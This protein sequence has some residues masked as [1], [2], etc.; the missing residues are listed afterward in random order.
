MWFF[1][2][3]LSVSLLYMAALLPVRWTGGTY[4]KVSLHKP[5][6]YFV[7]W[8]NVFSAETTCLLFSDSCPISSSQ[9][10]FLLESLHLLGKLPSKLLEPG[11]Y[12]W[13]PLTHPCFPK[14]WERHLPVDAHAPCPVIIGILVGHAGLLQR[15]KRTEFVFRKQRKI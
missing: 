12:P 6:S 15:L 7:L 5:P 3:C 9:T 8:V 11:D 2:V 10:F 4:L 13:Y 14:C 1:F